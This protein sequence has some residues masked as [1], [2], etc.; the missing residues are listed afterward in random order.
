MNTLTRDF[1]KDSI[2]ECQNSIVCKIP[3]SKKNP[4]TEIGEEAFYDWENCQYVII[5]PTV[6][7]ISSKAFLWDKIKLIISDAKPPK[8]YKGLQLP[9]NEYSMSLLKILEEVNSMQYKIA[10]NTEELASKRSDINRE[11]DTTIKSIE[12]KEA[13]LKEKEE[14]K[15]GSYKKKIRK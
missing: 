5:P 7:K 8:E 2:K 6:K 10:I 11:I 1:F 3:N 9:Y 15:I 13:S 12:T 4:I 14:A